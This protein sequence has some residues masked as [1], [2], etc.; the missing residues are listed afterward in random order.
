VAFEGVVCHLVA[1]FTVLEFRFG[2]LVPRVL[3]GINACLKDV[4]GE[5][6]IG[7]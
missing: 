2:F 5:V 7:G 6:S 3:D 1:P 4:L